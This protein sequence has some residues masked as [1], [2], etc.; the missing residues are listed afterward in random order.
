[1]SSKVGEHDYP[2]PQ[3]PVA[4]RPPPG[5]DES[6]MMVLHRDSQ[7]IEHR[8]F[9]DLNGFLQQGD[10][11]V[12]NNTR[13]LA[14]RRFSDDHAVEFLFLEKVGP[15]LW[16]CLIRPGRKMRIGATAKID[17]ETLRVEKIFRE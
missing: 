14:A 17:S 7:T 9:R 6:R 4:K 12:L 2:L 8:R 15:G 11:L 10:L 13:V 3:A 5:G 1:M 16:K